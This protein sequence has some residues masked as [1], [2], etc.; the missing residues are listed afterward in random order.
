MVKVTVIGADVVFVKCPLIAFPVPEVDIPVIPATGVLTQLKVVPAT[1][2]LKAIVV[3]ASPEQIDCEG[4]EAVASGVGFTTIV[5]FPF[6][7][8]EQSAPFW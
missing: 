5:A 1:L 3:M 2:P 8:L 6:V 7:G 4:T